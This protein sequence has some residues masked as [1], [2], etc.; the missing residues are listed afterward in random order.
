MKK[1]FVIITILLFTFCAFSEEELVIEEEI[2]DTVSVNGDVDTEIDGDAII[3][4]EKKKISWYFSLSPRV[5]ADKIQKDFSEFVKHRADSLFRFA[6]KDGYVRQIWYQP[7]NPTGVS[8]YLET[9]ISVNIDNR[10]SLEFGGGYAFNQMRSVYSIENSIDS[11][12]VLKITS[13]LLS[14]AFSF[15]TNYKV[16]FDST[17][18]SI[19]GIDN[20]GFFAG[21]AFILSRYSEHDTVNSLD[22]QYSEKN[23]RKHDGFGGSGKIGLFAQKNIGK[24]SIFEYS[25]GYLFTA[26]IGYDEFWNRKFYWEN[27]KGSEKILSIANSFILSFTL[28]F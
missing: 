3:P 2:L 24:N 25:I 6:R 27:T 18:F 7:A 4:T 8:F 11:T 1:I 14:N 22:L 13:R 15:S 16:C 10:M 23:Y 21:A 20:A 12:E 9:G 28:I 17:Y 26:T 19:N 5:G